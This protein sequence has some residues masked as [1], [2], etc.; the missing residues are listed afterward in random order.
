MKLYPLL[1][2]LLISSAVFSQDDQVI[3]LRPMPRGNLDDRMNIMTV[4]PQLTDKLYKEL[5]GKYDAYRLRG[6]MICITADSTVA[7][8]LRVVVPQ[9]SQHLL[10]KESLK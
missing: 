4:R 9:G 2:A 7:Q 6:G 8:K 5:P 1:T 3:D 10:N